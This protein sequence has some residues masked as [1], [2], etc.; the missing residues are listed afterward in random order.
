MRKYLIIFI[1][2]QQVFS[3]SLS[4]LGE[5]KLFSEAISMSINQTGFIYISDIA[6]NEIV[7]LDSSFNLIHSYGGFGNGEQNFDDP[8]DV[9]S[10]SLNLYVTDRNNN[11]IQVF[12]RQLNY[13]Y[14][15]SPSLAN[16]GLS[17]ISY[18]IG[19]VL[20]ASGDYFLLDEGNNRILKF[21]SRGNF[22]LKFG[23]YES[24]N[25]E[26]SNPKKILTDGLNYIYIIE[27]N[28]LL[29]FDLYGNGL[30]KFQMPFNV[31]SASVLN[32]FLL[33]NSN[34]QVNIYELNKFTLPVS[35]FNLQDELHIDE[36]CQVS[37]LNNNLIVL[38]KN[39]IFKIKILK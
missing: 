14:T 2:S 26:I 32:N 11:R 36:V 6:K 19:C 30:I 38:T 10:T 17:E 8:I 25:F 22:L 15:F 28:R 7:V 13:I 23:D 5:K 16:S 1:I 31:I 18:P 21:D 20:S 3:Q 12:D 27:D 35:S 37:L 9:F 34:F 33:I 24:G 4:I 39:K 29:I